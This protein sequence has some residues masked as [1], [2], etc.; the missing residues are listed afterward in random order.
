MDNG[1]NLSGDSVM[2]TEVNK[3][4]KSGLRLAMKALLLLAFINFLNQFDRRG[5][6]TVFPLLKLEWGLSDAQLGL[7]VSLFTLSR[8]AIVLPAGWLADKIG[9]L[10]VLRPAVFIW[11]IM[12]AFSGWAASFVSF[13]ALRVGVGL[14]DGVNGPLDLAYLGQV[15][16]KDKRGLYLSIYSIAL[17]AGSALGIVFAGAIGDRFGWRWV[18]L[19]PGLMGFLAALGLLLLPKNPLIP[20]DSPEKTSSEFKNPRLLSIFFSGPIPL[21]F[22]GGS[23]GVFASTGLV[24]WLPTYLTRQFDMSLTRAGLVTGGLILPA[25]ILG[26]VIGGWL[27]D[28]LSQQRPAARYW[29]ATV[30]LTLAMVFGLAG[31][32]AN[33]ASAALIWFFFSSLCFTL[34][35][36]PL[37]VL[38]QDAVPK[39]RLAIT[40][41]GFGLVTQVLGAAP[42]TAIVGLIS[43]NFGLRI[44]L[45][46]PFLAA[47]LGGV[48]IA[49]SSRL[50]RE[51]T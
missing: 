32:W 38:V 35:V 31:L 45:I 40:Q 1:D 27:G 21:M 16:P 51:K 17:Y 9:I 4:D 43:D 7:A 50:K 24:S 6:V 11:S 44:A 34:P 41:A 49:I 15:S 33:N 22:L 42:A 48:L 28:R 13:V 18:L 8:A 20:L 14:S 2:E 30:G 10:R 19:M 25:S 3:Q 47:A 26:T 29:L 46:A 39:N 37:L 5:L 23:F 36:S 12:A